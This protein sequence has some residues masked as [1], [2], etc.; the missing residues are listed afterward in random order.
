MT[1]SAR[2]V[3]SLINVSAVYAWLR[4]HPRFVDGVLAAVLAFG[5]LAT[6]IVLHQFLYIL[7]TL[8]LT[9]PV[10]F[11]RAHPVGAFWFAVAVGAVQLIVWARPAPPDLAIL[12]LLY[13]LA[14]YTTRRKSVIGLAACLFG[15]AAELGELSSHLVR[16][17]VA[18][19]LGTGAFLM[20][21]PSLLAWVLGDSMRYRRAYYLNLE[22]RAARLER[23]RD[24]QAQMAAAAERAR[25]A[26]ELHDVVAHNVSVMIVQ[27]DGA[28]YALDSEPERT[29]QALAAIATT[30]RQALAEMRVML[31]VLRKSDETARAAGGRPLPA[32]PAL[33]ASPAAPAPAAG[34]AA[35][36]GASLAPSLLPA[37]LPAAPRAAPPLPCPPCLSPPCPRLPLPR[38]PLPRL[39]RIRKPRP[40][41]PRPGLPRLCP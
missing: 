28:A 41:P 21:G 15:S 8:A 37:A 34:P 7:E 11:R 18:G 5:G 31:G 17:G 10:I 32:G 13:T 27:A 16:H 19:W 35:P 14:A 1:P 23:D 29:R 25:I 36:S 4:R 12:V 3:D 39:P 2:C 9:I 20:A 38:P 22:E 40:S 30:G 6:A 33:P 24:V 26:R